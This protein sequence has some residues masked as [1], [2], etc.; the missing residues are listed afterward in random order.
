MIL[1]S[2]Q[3]AVHKERSCGA[4]AIPARSLADLLSVFQAEAIEPSLEV[5][6]HCEPARSAQEALVLTLP[7]R[8]T[9]VERAQYG[10]DVRFPCLARPLQEEETS[11]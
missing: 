1:F 11:S 9:P 10:S 2:N 5:H 8:L 3:A 6:L 7:R 4:V